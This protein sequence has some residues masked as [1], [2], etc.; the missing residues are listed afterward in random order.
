M[1]ASPFRPFTDISLAVLAACAGSTATGGAKTAPAPA[2]AAA[3]PAPPKPFEYTASTGQYRFTTET[4]G[5]QSAMGN[6]RDISSSVSRL[7]TIGLARS[8]PDTIIVSLTIDSI[9][10]SNSM[11]MPTMGLDKVPGSKFTAKIAPNGSFYSVT[12]PTEA[13]NAL[14]AGMTDELGRA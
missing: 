11:G 12:G 3:A 8:T 2:A 14:A 1:T 6:S 5:T 7:M 13:E 9:T 10:S 4:K